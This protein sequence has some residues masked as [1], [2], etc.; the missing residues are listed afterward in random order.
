MLAAGNDARGDDAIGPRL[1]AHVEALARPDVRTVFDFQFQLEHALELESA[2]LALFIDSHCAQ[3]VPV[4]LSQVFPDPAPFST[5]HALSPAQVLAVFGRVVSASPPPAFLLSVA[6][7]SF[8]LGA[9]LSPAGQGALAA[10]T[11]L[12]DAM[13][14][15]PDTAQWLRLC[16]TGEECA[17]PNAQKI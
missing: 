3:P 6:G 7:E 15:A 9:S 17:S 2:D 4:R 8:V 1:L 13:L 10:A 12:L 16:K 11:V 5:S 14:E